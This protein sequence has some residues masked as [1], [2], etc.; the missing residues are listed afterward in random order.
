[1]L[2]LTARLR[3][4]SNVS[5]DSRILIGTDAGTP[6][7]YL[8]ISYTIGMDRFVRLWALSTSCSSEALYDFVGD[9]SN[10]FPGARSLD[11]EL[12]AAHATKLD[13]ATLVT[14]RNG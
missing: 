5:A 14:R 2:M 4:A 13:A 8:S 6:P 12:K 1:M 11:I 10:S 3:A 9:T 7:P